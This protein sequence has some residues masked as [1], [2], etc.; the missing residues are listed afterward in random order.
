MIRRRD[1]AE[2]WR[3]QDREKLLQLVYDC[4]DDRDT[5]RKVLAN[6]ILIRREAPHSPLTWISFSSIGVVACRFGWMVDPFPFAALI[7]GMEAGLRI[8]LDERII[9]VYQPIRP[10]EVRLGLVNWPSRGLKTEPLFRP[11][12]LDTTEATSRQYHRVSRVYDLGAGSDPNPIIRRF[13]DAVLADAGF[14]G[15]ETYLQQ[16]ESF[17]FERVMAAEALRMP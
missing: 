7:V 8:V 17:P 4:I 12:R 6:S 2:D 14:T 16:I 3:I 5:T 9:D 1:L 13:A 15:D 10:I 11:T